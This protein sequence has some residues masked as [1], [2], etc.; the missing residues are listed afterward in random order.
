MENLFSYGTLQQ[1]E[2]QLATFGRTL[3][4][5]VDQLVGYVLGEVEITD[6][7]VVAL[8]GK[9]FHPMLRHTGN[10]AD[11]VMGMVFRITAD[12]LAQADSY[13]V[14]AYRRVLGN[15]QSGG[16]AWIYANADEA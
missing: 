6:E 16:Q 15:M 14:A 3:D 7:A 5:V 1:T 10:P 11:T 12:E 4:G 2:V 13:E 9:R 8:S